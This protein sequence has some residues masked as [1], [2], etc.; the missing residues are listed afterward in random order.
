MFTLKTWRHYLYRATCEIYTDHKSLKYLYTHKEL[1]LRQHKWV[2]LIADYDCTI[3]YHPSKA[4]VVVDALSWKSLSLI[5]HIKVSYL[6]LLINLRFLSTDLAVSQ[7][8][9]L[10]AHFQVRPILIDQI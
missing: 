9:A 3:D 1:N 4:N 2:K 7:N 10:L 6:P 5:S 8:R